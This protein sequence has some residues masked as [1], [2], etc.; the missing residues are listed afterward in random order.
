[1]T[2]LIEIF[3]GRCYEYMVREEGYQKESEVF[4]KRVRYVCE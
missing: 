3:F 1:M 2:W 4:V